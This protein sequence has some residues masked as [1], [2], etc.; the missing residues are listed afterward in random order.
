MNRLLY[1]G[2]AIAVAVALGSGAAWWVVAGLGSDAIRLGSWKFYPLVG[3]T[4]AGEIE[5]ARIAHTGLLGLNRSEAI[6]F[7]AD[8]DGAGEGL[9]RECSYRVE[10]RDP[11]AR[12][13]S[14]TAYDEAYR[15]I[16]N[17]IDRYSFNNVN[18]AR[19]TTGEFVIRLAPTRQEGNW[20]PTEGE[21]A[22]D[23]ALRIYD[24]APALLDAIGEV[25]LPRI[26]REGCPDR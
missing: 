17:A 24:P 6:Y 22:F 26:T 8:R 1:F 10:G 11:D 3:S 7:I 16:P 2:S 9:R 4:A 25:E 13:W 5:R 12:W 23:L 18:V 14:I 20:I 15:L 21:G 19:G